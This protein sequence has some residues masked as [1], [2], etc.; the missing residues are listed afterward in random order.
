MQGRSLDAM[1]YVLTVDQK[2]SRR[3]PDRVPEAIA[4]LSKEFRPVRA[5]ERTVGD[6]FQG[7][8]DDPA[9]VVSVVL[10]LVRDGD[11]SIGVGVGPV[12]EPMPASTRAA[13]GPAFVLAREAVEAAK[14]RPQGVCVMAVNAAAG[15]A[16]EAVLALLA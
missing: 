16:A 14:R 9:E 2:H 12:E 8:L 10:D 5:F 4:R 1:P 7:V 13:R 3:S 6:E 15:R 11:W